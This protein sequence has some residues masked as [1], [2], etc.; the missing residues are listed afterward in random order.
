MNEVTEIK[1][2]AVD[3]IDY[4]EHFAVGV[5][6][7]S[8]GRIY[9]VCLDYFTREPVQLSEDIDGD[10][11]AIEAIKAFTSDEDDQEKNKQLGRIAIN[12]SSCAIVF[13]GNGDVHN[14]AYNSGG[15]DDAGVI[16]NY[17]LIDF[18][19]REELKS[20]MK[21]NNLKRIERAN[22][23]D[24]LESYSSNWLNLYRSRGDGEGQDWD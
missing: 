10:D 17:Q 4:V 2:V 7:L 24:F 8:D 13:S 14:N 20:W 1:V 22:L 11:D 18:D 16:Y 21:E 3:D 6:R 9:R 5:F 12:D 19:I 23:I 15:Y